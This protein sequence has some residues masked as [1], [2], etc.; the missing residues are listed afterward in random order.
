MTLARAITALLSFLSQPPPRKTLNN[1]PVGRWNFKRAPWELYKATSDNLLGKV[2]M[3][4]GNVETISEEINSAIL[5]AASLTIPR[6]KSFRKPAMTL[7]LQAKGTRH[8][9]SSTTLVERTEQQIQNP[10]RRKM[11]KSSTIRRRQMPTTSSLR[12]LKKPAQL[13]RRT[14]TFGRS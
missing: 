13:L 14:K 6:G 1:V 4:S 8:G 10:S 5:K 12:Q 9:L 11:E 7:T 2:D 3:T